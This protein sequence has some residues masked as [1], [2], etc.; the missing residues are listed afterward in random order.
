MKSPVQPSDVRRILVVK[1]SS[2]GDLFHALP[3][4]HNLKA[5]S[6]AAIDWLVQ[7]EY[8]DLV[9]CFTDVDRVIEFP[10]RGLVAGGGAFLDELRRESY[11]LVVDL[12]GLLKSAIP[13]RLARASLRIGPS[14]RREGSWLFYDAVAG[15]RNKE[16]HAVEEN[17]DVVRHLGW[18]ELPVEF[19]VKFPPVAAP[20]VSPRVVIV[21][22]SRWETKNWFVEGFVEVAEDLLVR[23]ATVV[24]AG[25]PAERAVCEAIAA[26]LGQR[27]NLKNLAGK[28]TLLELGGLLQHAQLA[29]TVDSGPMHMAA[30]LGVPVLALFGPTDPVRTGPYG[31]KSRV[32]TTAR[33]PCQPCFSG[34]C[35]RGDLACMRRIF[36]SQVL[37]AALDMLGARRSDER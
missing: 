22:A 14:F 29:I 33:L 26:P 35:D 6:G 8:A 37:A 28:T 20:G 30:A 24:L 21:P 31:A 36:P 18:P 1:L 10:R 25:G 3:A 15:R 34:Q 2:L 13:T 19:P 9:R 11:D 5:V 7:P 23:G 17:V 16:R 4:V 12:Q 27:P 32:L